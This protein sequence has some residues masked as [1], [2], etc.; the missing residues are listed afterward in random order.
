MSLNNS[1]ALAV[2]T[3]GTQ[4]GELT[5][6]NVTVNDNTGNGLSAATFGSSSTASI[7][8]GNSIVAG[9]SGANLVTFGSG[10][11]FTSLGNNIYDD[12]SVTSV[13]AS[14]QVNTDPLL[15]PLGDNG[16][17]T[18]T[19]ALLSGS[20]AI[21]RGNNAI[22]NTAGLTTDQRGQNRIQFDTVDIG[23]VESDFDDVVA[24]APVIT[25][26]VRDEGGVLARPDLINTYAVT[27]DQDVNVMLDDLL[28]LNQ[29]TEFGF[30][31][32]SLSYDSS[33][34]TATWDLG[35][36]S[37][38]AAFYTFQLSDSI[39]A[40]AGGRALDGDDDGTQGGIRDDEVY[41]A[42]PGDANLDGRV[43]VLSDA[44][45]LVANL[46]TNG[47]AVWA[48]GDFN[49][50]GDVSVLGDAFI[51]VANLNRDVRPPG[52]ATSFANSATA[53]FQSAP[54][55]SSSLV[56]AST[57]LEQDSSSDDDD[58]FGDR[59]ATASQVESR[60]LALAGA[61]DLRDDVFGSEF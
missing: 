40:V 49:G 38:S 53:Q 50:D 25:N 27:F 19:H 29:T 5:L 55:A 23:A 37:L 30:F 51:L 31:A 20:T 57:Q 32:D 54:T 42:I 22:A 43:D 4:A 9:S 10:S 36:L 12:A 48:Q 58:S 47:G 56:T 46:G 61:H 6:R 52:T 18:P 45:A 13:L 44:F 11:S 26:I 3:S 7:T 34:R 39:S 16:G 15:G 28:I 14:D 17:P 24:T 59:N 1:S 41:V 60:K 21:N 2:Q 8:V 35:S 33:S